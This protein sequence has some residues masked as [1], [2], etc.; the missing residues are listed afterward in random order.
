MKK[1]FIVSLLAWFLFGAIVG[2]APSI[3]KDGSS[4]LQ[5]GELFISRTGMLSINGQSAQYLLV[6]EE[7]YPAELRGIAVIDLNEKIYVA[8]FVE[9]GGVGVEGFFDVCFQIKGKEIATALVNNAGSLERIAGV[10]YARSCSYVFDSEKQV[11]LKTAF[12]ES[13]S[14]EVSLTKRLKPHSRP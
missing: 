10:T 2:A 6:P 4:N 3:K 1:S 13:K 12:S 7:K 14:V 8:R 9:P 5:F 11:L